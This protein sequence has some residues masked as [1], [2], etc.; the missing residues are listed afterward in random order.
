M[1]TQPTNLPVPS[2]SY[3]DLK[4]NAG[5]IDEFVTS[6]G[7][8]YTDRIGNKHY[9]IE[10]INHI[11]QEAMTSIGYV[12]LA[13]QTFTTGATLN[14][15]NEI[16][17]NEA[18]NSYY[19][20]TGTFA[21]GGKE[22]PPDSTPESSGGIGPG[23]WLNV[24]DSSLR[25]DL[26]TGGK[27]TLIGYN[28]ETVQA[29]LTRHDTDFSRIVSLD[30]RTTV[31]PNE[32]SGNKHWTPI[33]EEGHQ[34]TNY[35]FKTPV[36]V[37]FQ[38][39]S[40]PLNVATGPL[41]TFGRDDLSGSAAFW[42]QDS[43]E[44]RNA[45]IDG[46]TSEIAVFEPW[47]AHTA[48]VENNRILSNGE[49]GK[50]AINFKAQNW[51]P[52]VRGNTFADYTDKG[53]NF[54]KAADDEGSA[55]DKYSG[56]S[57][58]T[59]TQNR[60][61]WLGAGTGGVMLYSSGVAAS[62]TDNSSENSLIAIKLGYPSSYAVIDRLYNEMLAGGQNVIEIGDNIAA[63]VNN[64]TG[65]SIKNVYCNFHGLNTNSF[66]RTANNSVLLNEIILDD[67]NITNT[68]PVTAYIPPIVKINDLAFQKIIA[69]R[70]SAANMPL[71][72]MT[73]NY[74][75]VVDKY[76]IDIPAL[77]SDLVY[78][79][80]ATVSIPANASTA[81]AP[82]WFAKSSGAATFTRTGAGTPRQDLRNARYIG[83]LSAIAGATSTIYFQFPRADLINYEFVTIQ[84]LINTSQ[85]V[86]NVVKTSIYNPDGTKYQLDLRN[87]DS[88]ASWSEATITISSRDANSSGSLVTV[89][90]GNS[91]PSAMI[92]YVTGFRM[93]RGQYGMCG[94]ANALS[95][96]ETERMKS[97]YSYITP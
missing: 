90:I 50:Y 2:E 16:L 53:G 52:I 42:S 83:S 59:F 6:M 71:L 89:E 27:A 94:R 26:A 67:V 17:L 48:T 93:N 75:A 19:K 4:F 23:K 21:S 81:I 91:H 29:A 82:G 46:G 65:I 68:P 63:P 97:D 95:Y 51:W 79:D 92:T 9:T 40:D 49:P 96:A 55:T 77:N 3:R 88:A 54:C 44:L 36:H 24:G 12:I 10:G 31:P 47:T 69:G 76:G 60:C 8:T 25:S 35:V 15:P 45:V 39:S 85:A 14:S 43:Y 22:V 1:A 38:F 13:G 70:I 62:I 73:T 56:N 78:I 28:A 66:I 34:L 5:R 87:L 33:F 74:V 7:W 80:N 30:E 41:F 61:K 64:Y 84:F 86:T 37:D 18:D 20:W 57:R 58:L 32:Y 72:P 11:V